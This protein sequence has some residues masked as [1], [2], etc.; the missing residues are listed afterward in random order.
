[1][2][3]STPIELNPQQQALTARVRELACSKFAPRAA[4]YDRS[5]TFPKED[6]NDLFE[7]GLG[8]A[9]IPAEFGGLGLGP[10]RGN[11]LTLWLIT[12]EI[13]KADLSLAR[14]WEGHVN[15]LVLL[16]GIANQEQ[17]QRWFAGVLHN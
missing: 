12:R 14:C 2:T 5:A 13:A 4:E 16:D 1:M 7:A 11:V 15:S 8:A 10:Y 17:K 6:F 3:H 9:V